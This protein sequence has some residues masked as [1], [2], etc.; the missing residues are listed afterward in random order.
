M[1]GIPFNVGTSNVILVTIPS[2]FLLVIKINVKAKLNV[3]KEL[4]WWLMA[5]FYMHYLIYIPEEEVPTYV[6]GNFKVKN[7][8]QTWII[9]RRATKKSAISALETLRLL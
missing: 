7:R 5:N 2:V 6:V 3:M 9:R 8:N 4:H 1:Y